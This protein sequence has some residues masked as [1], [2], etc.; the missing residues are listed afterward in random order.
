MFAW[1]KA[2][3]CED[4]APKVKFVRDL[5]DVRW[6]RV[7]KAS[8]NKFSYVAHCGGLSAVLVTEALRRPECQEHGR[9][10]GGAAIVLHAMSDPHMYV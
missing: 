5:H 9:F 7:P 6:F 2:Y 4:A 3:S 8:Q 1:D 10:T